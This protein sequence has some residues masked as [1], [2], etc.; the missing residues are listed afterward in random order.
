LS[1]RAVFTLLLWP[2]A[3]WSFE[4]LPISREFSPSGSGAVQSYEVVNGGKDPIA[5]EVAVL[6]RTLDAAGL[7][8]N[9]PAE[10]DFLV[11]PPQFIVA[12][13]KRQTVRVSWLGEPAIAQELAFRLLVAQLPIERFLPRPSG[14]AGPEARLIV[15][16][17]YKGSLYIKPARA[18]ARLV[19]ESARP[20]TDAQ[21]HL[22]LI[23]DVR[24][25]GNA[26]ALLKQIRFEVKSPRNEA[27]AVL[28]P[29]AL[30]LPSTVVLPGGKRRLQ[31]PWPA[32]MPRGEVQV[33][34]RP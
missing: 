10:D 11:Y 13:G 15:L 2:L 7:E 1:P 12:P 8:T 22:L 34:V 27:V 17:R 29:A 26:R 3:A 19:V 33:S 31:F 6:T 25:A 30:D 9:A 18:V 21:G 23:L 24:N 14:G 4:L 20:D 32:G 16:T 5:I 28:T